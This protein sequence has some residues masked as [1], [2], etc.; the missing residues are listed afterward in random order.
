MIGNRWL[1]IPYKH[2]GRSEDGCDCWGFVR[3][4]LKEEKGVVLP[5]FEGVNEVEGMRYEHLFTPLPAPADWCLVKIVERRRHL[6]VG[7]YLE[8]FVIHMTHNGVVMQR[9]NRIK[10]MIRGYYSCM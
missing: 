7:L 3:L 10:G 1:H 6:H 5:S 8:G 2:M 9:T 4:V